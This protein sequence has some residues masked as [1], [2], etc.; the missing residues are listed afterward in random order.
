M[1]DISSISKGLLIPR[2]TTTQMLA[3]VLP[4]KSIL[5]YNTDVDLF[6]TNTGTPT[7][8]VWKAFTYFDGTIGCQRRGKILQGLT[9]LR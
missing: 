6:V 8:P 2:M 9:S 7:T 3:I 5:L 4:A 1:L